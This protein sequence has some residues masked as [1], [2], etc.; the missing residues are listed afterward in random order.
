MANTFQPGFKKGALFLVLSSLPLLVTQAQDY[1]AVAPKQVPQETTA[2]KLPSDVPAVQG[3]DRPILQ[4]LKAVVFVDSMKE[5]KS[6]SV[7]ASGVVPSAN[8]LTHEASFQKIVDPYLGQPLSMKSLNT[9]VRDIVLY[10]RKN[11]RPVVDVVVPEQDITNGVVQIAIVEGKVDAVKAEG[12]KWFSS[13]SIEGRIRLKPGD[14]IRAKKLLSDISWLNQNPFR[15]VDAVFA[16][17]KELGETDIVLRTNDR[18]PVRPYIGY[19]DT[20]N[21]LTG[22]ERWYAGFNWANPWDGQLSY[23]FTTSSD[24]QGVVAN[25]ASYLQPLPWRHTVMAYVAFVNSEAEIAPFN[26]TGSSAQAGVRY[27]IP[28]ADIG[29]YKQELY[30]GF[31]WK[32]SNN[33]LEFGIPVTASTTDIG[34]FV[35]GYRSSLPDA[36]GS[37]SFQVEGFYNPDGLFGHQSVA[38]Y[39][40]SRFGAN[41]DFGYVNFDLNRLTKLPA[42]FSFNNHLSF[43]VASTNLLASEQLEM[44]GYNSVRGYNDYDVTG[45]DE[46]WVLQ[47]ELRTPPVSVLQLVKLEK[48]KDQL[49]FLFFFDVGQARS[50]N[51]N[52]VLNNG[53]PTSE[54]TMASVGPGIRYAINPYLTVRADYGFQLYDTGDAKASRW[55]LGVMFAY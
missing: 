38:A 33:Q 3:D 4:K 24:F 11:D 42:D 5:V 26:L 43:Q 45:T 52:I 9:M 30:T 27:N 13:E 48:L 37:T 28:L 10:F 23:Q 40:A 47:N 25:S 41:P 21:D 53:N 6:G 15:S 32:Q 55:H 34:E 20:G 31:D 22:Y 12:N 17:G 46:G 7:K 44:G 19:E 36:W 51:G 1:Q 50:Q 39:G 16:P 35:F 29:A 49:Q 2:P 8:E 54:V 14:P 18:F